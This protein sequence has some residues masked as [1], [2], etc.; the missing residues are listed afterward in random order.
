MA[1]DRRSPYLPGKRAM[2][3]KGQDPAEQ[4]L[5]VGGWT[6]GTGKAVELGL[7]GRRVWDGALRN[8]GKIGAGFN[9]TIPPRAARGD[10]TLAADGP[11]FAEPPPRAVSKSALWLRPTS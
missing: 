4:E 11:P 10:R 9:D 5:V 2:T 3:G 1:K 6:K 7:A 8:A